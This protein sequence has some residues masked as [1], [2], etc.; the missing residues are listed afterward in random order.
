MLPEADDGRQMTDDRKQ[1]TEGMKWVPDKKF[2]GSALRYEGVF[3]SQRLPKF[4]RLRSGQVT[5]IFLV[6]GLGDLGEKL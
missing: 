3:V 6:D 4:L 2:L 1:M 5:E